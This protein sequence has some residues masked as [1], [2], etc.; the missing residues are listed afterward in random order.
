MDAFTFISTQFWVSREMNK[1]GC[2]EVFR[3]NTNGA[4]HMRNVTSHVGTPRNVLGKNM[5]KHREVQ[6]CRK[7][8]QN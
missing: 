8:R 2:S 1:W 6:K 4:E 3:G 7:N 5:T